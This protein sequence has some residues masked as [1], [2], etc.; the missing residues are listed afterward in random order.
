MRL[1]SLH[2]LL[3]DKD[4]LVVG[5]KGLISVA[6]GDQLVRVDDDETVPD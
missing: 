5:R 2:L 4:V 1:V 6:L 3:S